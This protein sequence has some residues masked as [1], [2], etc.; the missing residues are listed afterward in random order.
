[1]A[2]RKRELISIVRI[3][4]VM[5]IF[6]VVIVIAATRFRRIPLIGALP[7]DFELDLPGLSLYLPITTSVLFAA[8]ITV[9]AYFIQDSSNND[10]L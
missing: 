7:G 4:S 6:C 2:G 10:Q 5:T 1:V 8:V 9:I 3:V